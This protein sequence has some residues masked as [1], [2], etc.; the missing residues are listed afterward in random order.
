MYS[1]FFL[2]NILV[3]YVSYCHVFLFPYQSCMT[4]VILSTYDICIFYALTSLPF[5]NSFIE[6]SISFHS[7]LCH[8]S[9]S[10]SLSLTYSQYYFHPRY[11]N[12]L[13]IFLYASDCPS[14]NS[15]ALNLIIKLLDN[16]I[17][18]DT[19]PCSRCLS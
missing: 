10:T 19:L 4:N 12:N 8:D 3:V 18:S 16:I 17:S 5:Y 14:T 6:W 15:G 9:S 7:H 11:T 13:I 2:P 1:I